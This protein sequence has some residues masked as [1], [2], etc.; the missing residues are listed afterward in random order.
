MWQLLENLSSHLSVGKVGC[1]LKNLLAGG[2][3]ASRK[4]YSTN[5]IMNWLKIWDK[6]ASF[7]IAAVTST[8]QFF[9]FLSLSL[10]PKESIGTSFLIYLLILFM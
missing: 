10:N 9:L 3:Q 1:L 4:L 2:D 7:L 6:A 8:A 5:M